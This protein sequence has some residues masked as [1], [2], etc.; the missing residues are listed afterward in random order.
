MELSSHFGFLES[1]VDACG[2]GDATFY[3][4]KARMSFIKSH[5]SKPVQQTDMR[6]LCEPR[7]GQ[8]GGH[9]GGLQ[10]IAVVTTV[11]RYSSIGKSSVVNV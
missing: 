11:V 9:S 10:R 6:Q 5:A 2:N 8:G 4:E 3:L 1:A 7:Q